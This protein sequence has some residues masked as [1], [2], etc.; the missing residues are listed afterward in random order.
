MTRAPP[1]RTSWTSI[2]LLAATLPAAGQE[3]IAGRLVDASTGKPVAGAMVAVLDAQ[4]V[5]RDR[6]L[7]VASG[8]FQLSPAGPPPFSLVVERI[9]F[10]REELP[11]DGSGA[12][13]VVRLAAEAIELPGVTVVGESVCSI[14]SEH[15]ATPVA[16]AW[17]LV[18]ATLART[19]LAAPSGGGDVDAG[20]ETAFDV[21]MYDGELDPDLNFRRFDADTLPTVAETPFAFVDST[22]LAR[23]GWS[24]ELEGRQV[25]YFAPSPGLLVSAWFQS[26]HCFALD[27]AMSDTLALRFR[28]SPDLPGSGIE[29]AFFLSRSPARVA[30]AEFRHLI[31]G[32]SA[33]HQGGEIVLAHAGEGSWYVKEWWMRTP[34]FQPRHIPFAGP[35]ARRLPRVYELAGYEFRGGVA[36]R[37]APGGDERS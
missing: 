17:D 6:R 3:T 28:S 35:L 29:G 1:R 22:A 11:L 15:T 23:T 8:S 12:S 20:A 21:V 34:V 10:R 19:R 13:L 18:R 5:E 14:S 31:E 32:P 24:E 27:V 30:R 9:G 37:R 7:S 4:G 36:I 25:R 16:A 26:N 2:S 33:P